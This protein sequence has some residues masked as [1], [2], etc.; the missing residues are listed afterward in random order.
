MSMQDEANTR[1]CGNSKC[2]IF[3]IKRRSQVNLMSTI[4]TAVGFTYL[5]YI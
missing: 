3:S 1:Q 2:P 5:S 4:H